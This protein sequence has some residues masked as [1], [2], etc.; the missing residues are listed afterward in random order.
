MDLSDST[1]IDPSLMPSN[2]DKCVKDSELIP[3]SKRIR[4]L[5]TFCHQ[6]FSFRNPLISYITQ[7]PLS[8]KLKYKENGWKIILKNTETGWKIIFD[9]EALNFKNISPKF[10]V[11]ETMK[12][13]T[14]RDTEIV[15]VNLISPIINE[16]IY[17]CDARAL[18][19][20]EQ[21]VSYKDFCFLTSNCSII[22][23]YF[24]A[25]INDDGSM[26]PLEKIIKN[27][28]KPEMVIYFLPSSQIITSQTVQKM[29]KIPHFSNLEYF[30]LQNIPENFDIE[31][32]YGFIKENKRT[33]IELEFDA[34]EISNEYRN[35]IRKIIDE[36]SVTSYT[37][38][39]KHSVYFE[40]PKIKIQGDQETDD[41]DF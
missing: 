37:T 14:F 20:Y 19:I 15:D 22:S 39:G 23:F 18:V 3:F 27:L 11:I 36:I 32:F 31:T 41:E 29:I 8:A 10:W 24:A 13:D 38:D 30:K 2:S 6:S 16:K 40:K 17:K 34:D 21:N 35:R 4:F 28:Y 7:K 1:E 26:V 9:K 5:S 25:V 12:I 33:K